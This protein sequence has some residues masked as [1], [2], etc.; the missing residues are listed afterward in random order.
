MGGEAGSM[1]DIAVGDMAPDFTLVD[2]RGAE[3][4]LSS[5]RGRTSVLL[6]FTRGLT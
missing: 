3:V 2:T 6:V 5:F 1:K 4:K